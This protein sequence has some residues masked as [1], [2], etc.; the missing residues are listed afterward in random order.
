MDWKFILKASG[1]L[2]I[3][4]ILLSF[5]A[6][7][8]VTSSNAT[9]HQTNTSGGNTSIQGYE[10]TT[11]NTYQSGSSNDTTNTTNNSTNQKT[12]VNPANAPSMNVYGQ[13]SCVVPITSGVSFMT[14]GFSGGTYVEDKNC[15]RRKSVEMLAKLGMKVAAI[16]LM[17]QDPNVFEAMLVSGSPCPQLTEDGVSVIGQKATEIILEKRRMKLRSET[18]KRS[19]TWNEQPIPSGNINLAK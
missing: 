14:F 12:A 9:S 3:F 13:G 4:I 6:N 5:E 17:C 18:S 8:D 2:I 10:A 11:N 7:A 19:M 15:E 1:V 16:S